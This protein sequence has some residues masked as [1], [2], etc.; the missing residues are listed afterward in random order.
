MTRE[1]S[2]IAKCA[3]AN[4][5]VRGAHFVKHDEDVWITAPLT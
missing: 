1:G 4:L 5:E 2:S 3:D